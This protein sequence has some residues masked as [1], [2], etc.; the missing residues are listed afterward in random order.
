MGNEKSSRSTPRRLAEAEEDLVV[1][2]Y[3]TAYC[4]GRRG[5]L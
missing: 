2:A 5:D 3:F 4:G 1:P